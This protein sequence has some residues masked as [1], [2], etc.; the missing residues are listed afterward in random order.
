MLCVKKDMNYLSPTLSVLLL[1]VRVRTEL[2]GAAHISLLP[3]N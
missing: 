2:M 1:D 3:G